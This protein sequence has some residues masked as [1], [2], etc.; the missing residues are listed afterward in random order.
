[1]SAD[2]PRKRRAESAAASGRKELK[3]TR[4]EGWLV[5]EV[6]ELRRAASGAEVNTQRLR[7]LSQTEKVKQ[8]SQ[9]VLYWMCRD[10]RVQGERHFLHYIFIIIFITHGFIVVQKGYTY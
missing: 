3:L 1:M 5:A 8:G 10:Q 6:A 7:F 4:K 9:G 2:V